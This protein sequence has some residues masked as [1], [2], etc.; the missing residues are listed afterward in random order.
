M[1]VRRPIKMTEGPFVKKKGGRGG[2]FGV[3]G[4]KRKEIKNNL[5]S[6]KGRKESQGGEVGGGPDATRVFW[7]WGP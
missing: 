6:G 5:N 1:G 3:M 2:R 4:M 7:G